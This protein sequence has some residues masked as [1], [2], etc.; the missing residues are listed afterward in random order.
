M[1]KER[2]MVDIE[3]EVKK[4]FQMNCLRRGK[5]MTDMIRAWIEQDNAKQKRKG[6]NAVKRKVS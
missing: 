3:P 6:K 1:L 4:E 2:L 5:T